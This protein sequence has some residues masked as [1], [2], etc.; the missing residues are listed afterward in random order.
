MLTSVGGS[1]STVLSGSHCGCAELKDTAGAT[2]YH[3][4]NFEQGYYPVS[5]NSY[6]AT[7][8]G[9][10]SGIAVGS[11]TTPPTEDDY[12]IETP[13][14]SGLTF[15]NGVSVS[16]S[17]LSFS[18]EVDANGNQTLNYYIILKNTS[19]ESIT[20]SELA[21][22][23]NA[24]LVS[25]RGTASNLRV[26]AICLDRTLLDTPVTIAPGELGSIRYSLKAVV[27]PAS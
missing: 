26:A 13:I 18:K 14:T 12:R 23:Q 1:G 8:T 22:T 9:L 6:L 27:T 15:P 24:K 4:G 5:V 21:F 3:V 11:G 17:P 19:S 10:T 20:I 2:G 25:T 16:N 7:G